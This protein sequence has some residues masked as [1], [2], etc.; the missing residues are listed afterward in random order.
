MNTSSSSCGSFIG[1]SGT[2]RVFGL[3]E[4]AFSKIVM[5]NGRLPELAVTATEP[6][7]DSARPYGCGAIRSV[8]P[9]GCMMR[10]LG[11]IVR[12]AGLIWQYKSPAG[13]CMMEVFLGEVRRLPGVEQADKTRAIDKITGY[14][15][16]KK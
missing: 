14:V 4:S 2:C 11:I 7:G 13:G 12:S 16:M 15:F 9:I 10:P 5:E 6:S 3:P 8:W 1:P